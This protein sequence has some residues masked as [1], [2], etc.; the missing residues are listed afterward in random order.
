M[1]LWNKVSAEAVSVVHL[2]V[3]NTLHV[4]TSKNPKSKRPKKRAF[5]HDEHAP[6]MT[7]GIAFNED[8]VDM[9]QQPQ[10]FSHLGIFVC[11]C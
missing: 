9:Q 1:L 5:R 3:V 8:V 10:N 7:H 11:V 6:P 2:I 4:T